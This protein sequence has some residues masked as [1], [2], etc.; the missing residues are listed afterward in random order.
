MPDHVTP[1]EGYWRLAAECLDVAENFPLGDQK[2]ALLQMAQ[3]WQRLAE[4]ACSRRCADNRAIRRNHHHREDRKPT[5]VCAWAAGAHSASV[6]VRGRVEIE[7]SL[8]L[9]LSGQPVLGTPCKRRANAP[10]VALNS[11]YLSP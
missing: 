9:S 5:R 4:Q 1:A 11:A 10:D 3:I 2:D 8:L 7:R 6:A